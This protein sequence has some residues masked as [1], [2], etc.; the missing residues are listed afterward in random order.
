M[1]IVLV[2]LIFAGFMFFLVPRVLPKLIERQILK[3]ASETAIQSDDPLLKKLSPGKPAIIYFTAD[4]CAPCRNIQTPVLEELT[5]LMS[6]QL[7]LLKVDVDR[8][9]EVAKSWGIV[10]VPR[11]FILDRN[12]HIYAS[13]LDVATLETLKEQL[14]AADRQC[15]TPQPMIL[16]KRST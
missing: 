1:E 3:K 7:H 16:L 5:N 4:W 14:E 2:V 11:T 8:E 13:N 9:P 12:H 15:S 10:S 6:D